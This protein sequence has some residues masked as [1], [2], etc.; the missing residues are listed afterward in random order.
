M[1]AL[2]LHAVV[3]LCLLNLAFA[4]QQSFRVRYVSSDLIYIEAGTAAGLREG[5]RLT[6][7]RPGPGESPLQVIPIAELVVISVASTSAACEIVRA[8]MPIQPGDL[9]FID[10]RDLVV[11]TAESSATPV[12]AQLVEFRDEDPL[13]EELRENI[14]K[15]PLREVN[16]FGGRIGFEQ[17]AIIDRSS[18]GMNSNQQGITFR[19]DFTKIGNSNW[20]LDGYWRARVSSRKRDPLQESL[21]DVLHRVYHFSLRYDSPQSRYTAGFGRLLVPWASSLSTLD[22]GYFGRKIG[23]ATTLG[24]FAGSTPDPTAWNYAPDRQ[25]GG[26]F[27]N[28]QAGSF[29]TARYTGT[30]GIA[31]SR[32]HWKPE[33]Q[34]LFAENGILIGRKVALHH[35]VEV[36][37]QSRAQFS[38]LQRLLLSRSFFTARVQAVPRLSFDVNHNYFRVLPTADP[39]LAAAGLLDNVLFRGLNAG[40]RVEFP[41]GFTMYGSGGRS[42]RSEDNVTSWNRMGGIIARLPRTGFRAD[43]RYSH[44]SGTVA[45]GRYRSVALRREGSE[46][47]RFELEGGDQRF[48]SILGSRSNAWFATASADL[49]IGRFVLGFRNTRYRSGDQSYDQFRTG[50]DFRF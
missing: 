6:I 33:R 40:A 30:A 9:A 43:V 2:C 48:D 10:V 46:R 24:L 47:W 27:T 41:Y 21:T 17:D 19:F 36:D 5:M 25:L 11:Q 44:F 16:H 22:G 26:V 15:P 39:R 23:R 4:Q 37:Y 34:F 31:F 42:R 29:D 18:R 1:K 49:F 38:S 13:E 20:S 45:T 7:K 8:D 14:P 32:L 50:L 35:N 3:S 12:Y 28:F